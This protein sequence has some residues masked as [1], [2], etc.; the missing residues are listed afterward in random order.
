MTNV[1]NKEFVFQT[2]IKWIAKF[3]R[4]A[5][6]KAEPSDHKTESLEMDELHIYVQKAKKQ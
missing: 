6:E 3:V 1:F 2:I 4:E 5:I